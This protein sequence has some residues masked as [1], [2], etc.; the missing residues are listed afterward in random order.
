[1]G[2]RLLDIP[3][4]ERNPN[5]YPEVPSELGGVTQLYARDP[6]NVLQTAMPAMTDTDQ[7]N[8]SKELGM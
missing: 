8:S 5:D 3:T 2:I 7:R 1:M 6:E 4:Y